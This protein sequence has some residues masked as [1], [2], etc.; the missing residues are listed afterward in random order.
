MK[1]KLFSRIISKLLI[2]MLILCSTTIFACV[3]NSYDLEYK[4]NSDGKTCTITGLGNYSSKNL[5]IPYKIGDYEVT[6]IAD[7]AF[8]GT[9][10]ITFSGGDNIITIGKAAFRNCRYL[11]MA[12]IPEKVVEIEEYCFEFCESLSNVTFP[13]NLVSIGYAA[14]AECS[15]LVSLDIPDTVLEIE[16]YA[17]D[18]CKSLSNIKLPSKLRSVEDGT[19]LKCSSLVTIN[20]PETVIRIGVCAFSLCQSLTSIN[21]PN[22][23]EAI[24]DF[25]FSGCQSLTE[26]IIPNSVTQIGQSA[27]AICL[28]L[29]EIHFPASVTTI[30]TA[31]L[32]Y[33]NL[34]SIGVDIDNPVLSSI[35]GNLYLNNTVFLNY[36]GGKS[37]D[38]FS[39]PNGVA[40]IGTESFAGCI[41]LK[42]ISIPQSVN[43]IGAQVFY[44]SPNIETIYY[45]GTIADWYWIVKNNNWNAKTESVFTIICTDGTIAMDGTVTYN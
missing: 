30:G 9:D 18:Q 38:F 42:T 23:V 45:D 19:F 17:F 7:C 34:T 12:L 10:I 35:D 2:I 32:A 31:P 44:M 13:Q 20:I 15:S 29:T 6:A 22:K 33:T 37:D 16:G 11:R 3:N 5:V 1:P 41:N 43:Y 25:A 36:A 26:I 39:I 40:Q 24:G 4:V 21:I 8:Q 14:F 27:F 28:S